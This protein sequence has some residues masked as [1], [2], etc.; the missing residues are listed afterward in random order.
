MRTH[1][2]IAL[3]VLVL[4]LASC[5]PPP[6]WGAY[7]SPTP[8]ASFA[9]PNL[10]PTATHQPTLAPT[11][12][13]SPTQPPTPTATRTPTITPP[14][15]VGTGDPPILY[16][17]QSG[18]SL[19]AV[20]AH[21]GVEASRI[22][23][24]QPLPESGFLNPS[25]LLIIPRAPRETSPSEQ[26]LPDSEF[27]Y[28]ASALD[29]DIKAYTQQANGYLSKYE[30]YLGSTGWTSGA[31]AVERIAI[32]NSINPRL[33]LALLEYESHWVY[34]QPRNFAQAEY[35][36]GYPRQ[37]YK[38]LFRQLMLAVQDLSVGYYDWRSGDL[39]ELTF[40]DGETLRIAPELN[41]ASVAIQYYFAQKYNRQ[42]WQQIIDP[43]VGF[44]A[45]YAE[46]FG[47][48]W[49]RA[50]TVEPLFP[51]ALIQPKLVLPFEPDRQW[52]LTGGPHPAWE[53]EGPWAALDFAPAS[54]F[55][56]CAESEEWL[57]A[58]APGLVVR[59]GNGIVVLDLDGDGY[60][61]T[62]WS[63]VYLHVATED[64]VPLGTW[65]EQDERI[66]HPSCE[67]GV[68][69]GTHL[70]FVRK[71]N[72]EW[73]LAD[74]P[75]PFVLSGWVAHAGESPYEGT[76]T[77]GEEVVTADPVGSAKSIIIRSPEK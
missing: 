12:T 29:F 30:E 34:G 36:L 51:P 75:I 56:G 60:E 58:S 55:S 24:P 26:I 23:S 47:D 64:R 8:D 50:L 74:G 48:P 54:E 18:D 7:A 40:P 73:I 77:K 14:P 63:L 53:H 32:E 66:G 3:T 11:L 5:A 49:E 33:L 35:P 67:G 68:A 20:A 21:F 17:S 62:G 61:Q 1:L 27:V 70:H 22:T 44:P 28:S 2:P 4:L 6:L 76:L 69:T 71:Y 38:G 42:E 57:V 13:P 9:S 39:T 10:I 43:R 15:F 46:M 31:Q 37:F 52:N 45:K 41:A 19:K 65:V 16:Y 72:G 25:T 59:S